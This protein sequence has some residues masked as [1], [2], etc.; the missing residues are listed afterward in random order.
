[1]NALFVIK[2]EVTKAP[3]TEVVIALNISKCGSCGDPK[4]LQK[5]QRPLDFLNGVLICTKFTRLQFK[6]E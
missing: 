2:T 4:I 6:M 3:S 5:L 1:M